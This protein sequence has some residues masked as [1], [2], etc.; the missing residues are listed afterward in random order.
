[1]SYQSSDFTLALINRFNVN[2]KW[3][4]TGEGEV[5]TQPDFF[6]VEMNSEPVK[7]NINALW[8]AGSVGIIILPYYQTLNCRIP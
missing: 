1:M 3:I 6:E 4:E 8:N 5:F 2:P 7:G